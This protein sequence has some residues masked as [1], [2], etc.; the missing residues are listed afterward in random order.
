[1]AYAV[2]A[3]LG[4]HAIPIDTGT[5]AALRVL[6]LVTDKDAAAGVVPG[7]ERAVAKAKGME[8]G[9]LLHELGADYSANPVLR[10]HPRDPLADRPGVPKPAAQAPRKPAAPKP[11]E[12]PRRE[13][14]QTRQGSQRASDAAAEEAEAKTAE[15]SG[16]SRGEN[17]RPPAPA[18]AEPSRETSKKKPAAPEPSPAEPPGPR[19]APPKRRA[20][21]DS[22]S[23]RKP[24]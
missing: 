17:G 23:K 19:S 4:G 9:S 5:M 6:D 10:E 24:R 22:L 1:M 8:F 3:A 16:K 15:A 12:P 2:Q 7:L 21:F 14:R 11:P 13:A 18:I 20:A